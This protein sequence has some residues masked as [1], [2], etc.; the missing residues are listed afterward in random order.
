MS[1]HHPAPPSP[2]TTGLGDFTTRPRALLVVAWALPVGAAG[3]VAS[4]FLLRLIGLIG[5]L[6]F[7]QRLGTELVDP[8]RVH[9]A[10]WLVLGA[11]VLGGLAVGLLARH[12]SEKIRGH[13]MPE[14]I[15]AI[16][17]RGGVVAP[18]L[19]LLKPL[20]AAISIGT[21]GPFG[22]EG[23]VIMT[24]GAIGSLFG[25][26]LRLTA[27]ERRTLLVAGSA[28]GMAATFDA[29]MAS[30]L[31][32]VELLLFEWRPRSLVPV[33]ASVA[34]ATALRVPL[35]GGGPVFP[36]DA[37]AVHLTPLVELLA[38]LCGL[39]GGALAVV[40]TWMVYRAEDAFARL[41]FHWMWWPALGGL[42]IGCGGL[43]EPR[44]LGVGYDVVQQLL[45]GRATVSLIVGVLVVKSLIW[46]LSLGSGTS[47]GVLAPVLMIGGALGA[48]EGM[49]FPSVVP[50]FW[51][52]LGLAAVVGG[53]LRSPL[54]GVVFTLELTHAWDTGPALLI[55]ATSAYAL[56]VL[57]LKRS[58]LTE[59]IARRGLHLTRE[60]ATD[61]LEAFFVREAMDAAPSTVGADDPLDGALAAACAERLRSPDR[62]QRLIPVL[63][64][65]GGLLGIITR[66]SL[67]AARAGGGTLTAADAARPCRLTV[68]GDDTLRR[69]ACL[70]AEH[71]LTSAPVVDPATGRPIGV[72]AL[73]DLLHARRHQ[74]VQEG[75]R[76]RVIRP[77]GR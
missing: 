13:G 8:G 37:A 10:W 36:V 4:W 28:A 20:S 15:E 16:L 67:R 32:A 27:A 46:A 48:W 74:L 58:L 21:G 63:R 71:A 41:P 33:V 43:V 51:A 34:V 47:G 42:V 25:Q 24:G 7:R 62:P 40:T 35:L 60:Y 14:A 53:V 54:T 61:P 26:S 57:V 38:V 19:A 23:P 45:A 68:R 30:V 66:R 5:N 17:T 73:R 49:L 76:E 22:A 64:P 59:K 9:P 6:V 55:S 1:G 2:A 12:G 44:A 29:P 18:R 39:T 52:M 77:A 75:H 11:P 70:F 72:I 56:S 3:A 31:L 69:V 50:G 65:D